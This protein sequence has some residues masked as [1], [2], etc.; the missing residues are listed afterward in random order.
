MKTF[1][2][3]VFELCNKLKGI[4]DFAA[5]RDTMT[6]LCF[7]QSNAPKA[8]DLKRDVAYNGVRLNAEFFGILL[9][10]EKQL[11]SFEGADKSKISLSQE[12]Y[13][14]LV[15]GN[16]CLMNFVEMCLSEISETNPI[17]AEPIHPYSFFLP[18]DLP[19]F[20]YTFDFSIFEEAVSSFKNTTVYKALTGSNVL[21]A[22][23]SIPADQLWQLF[24]L[25]DRDIIK[26]PM[27]K[28]SDDI[29]A[30][31]IRERSFRPNSHINL[32]DGFTLISFK[33]LAL[34]EMLSNA[35]RLMYNAILGVNLSVIDENNLIN[36]EK[37]SSNTIYS[38]KTILI[39]GS[40]INPFEDI[41]KSIILLTIEHG[42]IKIHEFGSIRSATINFASTEG[43]T[44]KLSY[45]KIDDE[46][47]PIF[48]L[49]NT[50]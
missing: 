11:T 47:N 45:C 46:L 29:I 18:I 33:L 20:S 5:V 6:S 32:V 12:E 23:A 26:S 42:N 50:K 10:F 28:V 2:E 3:A 35:V 36:I 1:R 25:L 13:Q 27:D 40:L 48:G 21:Q 43:D 38:Y 39:Q 41:I 17:V 24:L 16:Y 9:A 44:S 49:T 7:A 8:F 4:D 22:F 30:L 14:A 37:D 31:K 34:R 15:F 19:K